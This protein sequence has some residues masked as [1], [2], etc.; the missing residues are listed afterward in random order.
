MQVIIEARTKRQA[1]K[2]LLQGVGDYI[3]GAFFFQFSEP[4]YNAT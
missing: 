3:A 2:I 1:E 4:V